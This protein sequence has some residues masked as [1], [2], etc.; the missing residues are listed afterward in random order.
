M[1]AAILL[2][3]GRKALPDIGLKKTVIFITIERMGSIQRSYRIGTKSSW[4]IVPLLLLFV[5]CDD[6]IAKKD[7][8]VACFDIMQNTGLTVSFSNCSV[9]NAEN[10]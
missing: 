7:N 5:G 8:P 1:K 10:I 3:W 6:K 2:Y 4:I 9:N